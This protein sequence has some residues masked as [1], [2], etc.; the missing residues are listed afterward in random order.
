MA[1]TGHHA[2]RRCAIGLL[3]IRLW[4]T[5]MR[6]FCSYCLAALVY[7]SQLG[8]VAVS[9]TCTHENGDYSTIVIAHALLCF[10]DAVG[11]ERGP[12]PSDAH[13]S[14]RYRDELRTI[15]Q[16]N[17]AASN[18]HDARHELETD[19]RTNSTAICHD[20]SVS[21]CNEER[22]VER[23]IRLFS[24]REEAIKN[25]QVG[26]TRARRLHMSH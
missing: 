23:L 8:I 15:A 20:V 17:S 25:N 4:E 21:D 10:V 19:Q 9:V 18:I 26:H 24:I 3:A 22:L 2:R 16:S 14:G 7:T 13:E 1:E 5:K 6:R 12:S 11:A